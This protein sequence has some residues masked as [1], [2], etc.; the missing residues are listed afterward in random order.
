MSIIRFELTFPK[1]KNLNNSKENKNRMKNIIY[2]DHLKLRLKVRKI[3]YDYPKKIF[4]NPERTFFDIIEGNRIAIKR[5]KYNK[6]IRNMM[7]AY[8]IKE[9][10]IEIVT[11]HPIRE[12]KIANRIINNRWMEN[13]K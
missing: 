8:E 7:I 3:P 4:Q 1:S 9:N 11:I 2:T 10:Q 13:G 6:E 5:L 12:E